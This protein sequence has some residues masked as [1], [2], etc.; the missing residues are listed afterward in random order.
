MHIEIARHIADAVLAELETPTDDM[1][2]T[3]IGGLFVPL[4]NITRDA[5]R[6]AWS[7][8]IRAAREGK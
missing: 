5:V 7:A 6:D 8:A 2:D 4:N 1:V 3:I